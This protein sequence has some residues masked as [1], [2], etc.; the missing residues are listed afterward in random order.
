MKGSVANLNLSSDSKSPK[1][2]SAAEIDN[3]SVVDVEV[4]AKEAG[5]KD[6]KGI[7]FEEVAEEGIRSVVNFLKD[8]IP[9]LKV[10]VMKINVKEEVTE[11]DDVKQLMEEEDDNAIPTESSD[12]GASDLDD[13]QPEQIATGENSDTGE[14]EKDL[15]TKL[16]IGGV[17]HNKEDNPT[18]DDYVRVPAEIKEMEK[19]SF[20]LHIPKRH[21]DNDSEELINSNSRFAHVAAKDVSKLMPPDVAKAF[22]SSDKVSPEVRMNEI[23]N[24]S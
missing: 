2:L 1:G 17:L 14:D 11:D 5:K 3:A 21:K 15:D 6:E 24:C 9:E 10:K 23:Q 19:D 12:E 7:D 4:S 16:F 20:V 8:K 18:K 13:M 22:W